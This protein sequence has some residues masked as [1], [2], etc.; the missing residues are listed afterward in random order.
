[1]PGLRARRARYQALRP[2]LCESSCLF[3]VMQPC[4]LRVSLLEAAHGFGLVVE[5]FKNR[6]ELGDLQQVFDAL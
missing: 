3:G 5:R 2:N 6:V 4:P 1:M